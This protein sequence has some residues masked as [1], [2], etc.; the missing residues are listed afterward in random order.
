MANALSVEDRDQCAPV[1]RQMNF[2]CNLKKVEFGNNLSN[3]RAVEG[4]ELKVSNLS[5]GL[6][7]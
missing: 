4:V 1:V 5:V 2:T 7:L 6:R 3:G